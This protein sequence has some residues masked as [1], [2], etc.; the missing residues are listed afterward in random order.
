MLRRNVFLLFVGLLL[1]MPIVNCGGT[2]HHVTPSTP[3]ISGTLPNGVTGVA[4]TGMLT[5]TGGVAPFTWS[6]PGL[7][8]T[9]TFTSSGNT[10]TI[11]GTPLVAGTI[12]GNA[13]V[14][15]SN[16][17]VSAPFPYSFTIAA[18]AITPTS[19]AQLIVGLPTTQVLTVSPATIGPYTWSI[20]AG[21]LPPGLLLS[22]GTTTSATTVQTTTNTVTITGTPTTPGSFNFS[23]TASDSATPPNTVLQGYQPVV[24]NSNANAC[25]AGQ[26]NGGLNPGMPP[27]GTSYAFLLRG[28]DSLSEPF[29]IAGSF[30]ADGVGG[31][32]AGDVDFNGFTNGPQE[33]G[34]SLDK[35]DST[36]SFGLSG[37]TDTRGC[38]SLVFNTGAAAKHAN[39]RKMQGKL[40][41]RAGASSRRVARPEGVPPPPPIPSRIV[42]QFALGGQTAGI[43]TTGNIIE[44]DNADGTG[45][46]A[47]GVM[48]VQDPTAFNVTSLA[49]NFAF[50]AAGWDPEV[51]RVAIAG[52]FTL[53]AGV[54]N[55]IFADFNDNG[56]PSGELNGGANS[57]VINTISPTG[58][59]TGSFDIPMPGSPDVQFDSV[60]YVINANDFYVISADN[61]TAGTTSLL[62]GRALATSTNFPALNGPY[63]VAAEGFDSTNATNVVDVGTAQLS[64]TGN[65]AAASLT[66]NDGGSVTNITFT[67]TYALDTANPTSGRVQFTATA[68]TGVLPVVYLTSGGDGIESI[69]GFSVGTDVN[70]SSGALISQNANVLPLISSSVSGTYAFGNWEDVDGQN[71]AFSGVA[72]LASSTPTTGTIGGT[73]DVTFV[74][75]NPPFLTLGATFT[76]TFT[77][78]PDGSGTLT[79]G[80]NP[81]AFVTNGLQIFSIPT[82][83]T[84]GVLSM[85]TNVFFSD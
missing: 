55:P 76:G 57:G 48:H 15:D 22:N 38:L 69:Q 78:N 50:G 29:V 42:F 3:V 14:T 31:I 17:T 85:Y 54:I 52:S 60:V 72:T 1:I 59:A 2:G 39:N 45:S 47:S 62:S 23:I 67:G 34:T 30:T 75:I 9:L 82:G 70:V 65:T 79:I 58:R 77:I 32:T 73:E 46:S 13:T 16:M 6:I 41:A 84:D 25:P 35:T 21:V 26:N 66:Q 37:P 71:G 8:A 68:G 11:S 43:Y 81:N 56:T 24:A 10:V 53:T 7:P 49:P 63:V 19:L 18:Q 33:A 27:A 80:T 20:V 4:Y 44:F 61:P 64:S 36:Y 74:T 51:D 83:E 40:T 12:S 5:V 28:F